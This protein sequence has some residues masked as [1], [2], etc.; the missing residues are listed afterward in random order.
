MIFIV[1]EDKNYASLTVV[2]NSDIFIYETDQGQPYISALNIPIHSL[3]IR[4]QRT[5]IGKRSEGINY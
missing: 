2:T 3:C 5:Q 4:G 1:Y